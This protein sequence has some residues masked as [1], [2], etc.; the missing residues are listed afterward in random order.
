MFV[1]PQCKIEKSN[2]ID[3]KP[4]MQKSYV[5]VQSY[6]KFKYFDIFTS[7]LLQWPF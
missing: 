3:F 4:D 7:G 5:Y 2:Q 6:L 1:D